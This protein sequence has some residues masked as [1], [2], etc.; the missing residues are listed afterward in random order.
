MGRSKG[1]VEAERADAKKLKTGSQ[2]KVEKC[3]QGFW[4]VRTLAVARLSRRGPLGC[5]G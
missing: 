4:L 5:G 3:S 1:E 2:R